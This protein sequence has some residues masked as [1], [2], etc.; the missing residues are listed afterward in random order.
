MSELLGPTPTCSYCG[1]LEITDGRGAHR[2]NRN[3]M[4]AEIGRLRARVEKLEA[5]KEAARKMNCTERWREDDGASKI[6]CT[7]CYSND[8]HGRWEEITHKTNCG[9]ERL[10]AAL[11]ALEEKCNE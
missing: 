8:H 2:C 5:V 3:T 11:A 4:R 7:S 9:W 1:E 10:D 6:Y